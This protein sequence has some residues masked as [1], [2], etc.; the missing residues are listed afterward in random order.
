MLEI[1]QHF[2]KNLDDDS[3][4][5]KHGIV[6][7]F[8]S[9]DFGTLHYRQSDEEIIQNRA[10]DHRMSGAGWVFFKKLGHGPW[11]AILPLVCVLMGEGVYGQMAGGSSTP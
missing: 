7:E 5:W 9:G 3:F 10:T 8:E 6:L 1:D 4:Y 11:C 2:Q